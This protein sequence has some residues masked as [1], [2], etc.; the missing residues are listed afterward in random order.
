M[1][2]KKKVSKPGRPPLPKGNAKAVM[3][4]VRITQDESKAMEAAAKASKK[5]V[6][7]WVRS[8]ITAAL[9]VG[10][11]FIAGCGHPSQRFVPVPLNA[12]LGLDTKTGQICGTLPKEGNHTGFPTCYELYQGKK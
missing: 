10:L 11:I 3:L 2:P 7:D 4:R 1:S 6:S 9:S 8:L 12:S 5:T